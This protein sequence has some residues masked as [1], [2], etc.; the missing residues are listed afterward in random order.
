MKACKT[1]NLKGKVNIVNTEKYNTVMVV[2]KLFL[3]LI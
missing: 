3:F 2:H 1:I